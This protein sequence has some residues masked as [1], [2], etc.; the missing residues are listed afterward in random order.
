M[1]HGTIFVSARKMASV[2]RRERLVRDAEG[3]AGRACGRGRRVGPDL[4]RLPVHLIF[5]RRLALAVD[6]RAVLADAEERVRREA[7]L[8]ELRRRDP[9]LVVVGGAGA[10]VAAGRRQVPHREQ[11]VRD[12]DDVPLGFGVRSHR[13]SAL[14]PVQCPPRR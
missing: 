4:I 14:L 11:V 2:D 9:D 7:P 12:L 6:E 1:N 5:D 10:Q 3:G 8:V 13:A